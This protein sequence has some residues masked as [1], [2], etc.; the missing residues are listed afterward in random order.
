MIGFVFF[1][2]GKE[3]QTE[4][5]HTQKERHAGHGEDRQSV[6]QYVFIM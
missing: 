2:Y 4:L 3:T 6:K 5:T 1:L